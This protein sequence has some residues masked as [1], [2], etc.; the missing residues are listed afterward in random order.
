M[1]TAISASDIRACV[2]F[3]DLIE[4]VSRAFEESS[5]GLADNGLVVMF[6]AE[7]RELGDV[8]VKTGTLRG[9][10]VYIVKVSPW[11]N[12]NVESGAPQGGFVGVFDSKTGRTI[13]LLN[14]EH[15]LSDVR[16]AAAGALAA[17]LLAPSDVQT[18]A[19]LG[20]GV[21]AYWQPLALYGERPFSNLLIWARNPQ[22]AQQLKARLSGRLPGVDIRCESDIEETVRSADVLITATQARE[23]LVQGAWLHPGMHITA[24]GADDAT[25]CELDSTALRRARVFV[26]TRE[27]AAA[28]GDVHRAM[29]SGR[30]ALEELSGE[31][32]EVISG[33]TAGRTSENDVTIAKF[34]GIG[35][36]DLVAAEVTLA[37][38]GIGA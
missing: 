16:T 38:L 15:Y 5:A 18:V 19:V 14:D 22:K 25:K 13:A 9:H 21:Q 37:K 6:P 34:V 30:Y 31:L 27:S 23:P 1:T 17:R 11:F 26:D 7:T 36:Q 20:A 2:G 28:N 3:E 33:K 12:A 10:G 4:P 8:Y 24:V 32:G 29:C 35:A